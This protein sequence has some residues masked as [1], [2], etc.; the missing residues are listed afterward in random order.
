MN[1]ASWEL[2]ASPGPALLAPFAGLVVVG[3]LIGAFIWG[4]RIR[5]REAR[6]PR[7]D[8]QPKLPEGGPVREIREF[9][10]PDE[11]PHD[12]RRLTPHELN[13]GYGTSSTHRS[14]SQHPT[15]HE[16]RDGGNIASGDA[17]G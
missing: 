7:P 13:Q 6:P 15:D 17:G 12:G 3:V 11:M 10:E 8:E 9:R 16:D 2:A 14:A 4:R 5:A 1:T